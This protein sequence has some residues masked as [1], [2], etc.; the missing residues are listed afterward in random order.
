VHALAFFM[1]ALDGSC[2][3]LQNPKRALRKTNRKARK[4]P[5]ERPASALAGQSSLN[6]KEIA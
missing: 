2:F 3:A 6:I 5:T 4:Q 1:H